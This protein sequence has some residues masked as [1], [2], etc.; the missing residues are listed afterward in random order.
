[1]GAE[2]RREEESMKKEQVRRRRRSVDGAK[3]NI[4]LSFHQS[5]PTLHLRFLFR[6][7]YLQKCRGKGERFDQSQIRYRRLWL[8]AFLT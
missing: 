1:M 4:F 7:S 5:S 2:L 6:I 3:N 8:W